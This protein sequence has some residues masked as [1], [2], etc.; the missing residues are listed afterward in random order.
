MRLRQAGPRRRTIPTHVGRT[1]EG[2]RFCG[3][4][5]DHPHARGENVSCQGAMS[6]CAGPSPRTWGEPIHQASSRS[7]MRTIPTHVGRTSGGNRPPRDRPDHPHARG[8]NAVRPSIRSSNH[9]PSPRTWGELAAQMAARSAERTIPT[10]VGRTRLNLCRALPGTDHPHARG[11][12]GQIAALIT[13]SNG[14]SPR[15]WGEPGLHGHAGAGGRTIPT[16]VGR[17]P[18]RSSPRRRPT[19]HPHARGENNAN[20]QVY[21]NELGPSPRTWGEP[22]QARRARPPRRTIPT[23]VGRTGC[24]PGPGPAV[25][26]HPHARGENNC[27]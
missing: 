6:P 3:H 10:H 11:E 17:T 26:D 1:V 20:M 13:T 9:G 21:A 24:P 27:R 12:N 14:P 5:A 22:D 7:W 8:E 4:G 19:D 25:P 16:H 2:G 23:H 18:S 15:T